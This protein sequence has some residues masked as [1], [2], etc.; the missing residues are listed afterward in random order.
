MRSLLGI[1]LMSKHSNAMPGAG[2]QPVIR[3]L[4]LQADGVSA[5]LNTAEDQK[6]HA[7]G[8]VL[9]FATS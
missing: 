5:W 7:I 2:T 3:K 1:V 4:L 9:E 8:S 6:L